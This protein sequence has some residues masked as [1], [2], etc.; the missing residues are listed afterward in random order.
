MP[1]LKLRTTTDPSLQ[2]QEGRQDV[3]ERVGSREGKKNG[4]ERN[5]HYTVSRVKQ[6]LRLTEQELLLMVRK[7]KKQLAANP[8]P[9]CQKRGQRMGNK[10]SAQKADEVC[11]CLVTREAFLTV[12]DVSRRNKTG[13]LMNGLKINR[14]RISQVHFAVF[15]QQTMIL[16]LVG[17]ISTFPDPLVPRN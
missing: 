8:N 4:Q 3:N 5:T 10:S 13:T 16:S 6:K 2:R 15:L 17:A 7:K 1:I 12:F 14:K 9:F 11:Y